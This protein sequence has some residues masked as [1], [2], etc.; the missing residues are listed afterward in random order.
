MFYNRVFEHLNVL[1]KGF[2]AIEVFYNRVCEHTYRFS[3]RN[4]VFY[5]RGFMHLHSRDK[6]LSQTFCFIIGVFTRRKNNLWGHENVEILPRAYL[7]VILP[8]V[9]SMLISEM[10]N[11]GH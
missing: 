9:N 2:R 5:N 10:N 6:S 1:F 7:H 11:F 8:L 3:N 4:R